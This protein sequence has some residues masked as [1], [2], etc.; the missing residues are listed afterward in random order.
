MTEL[1]T[2]ASSVGM[3]IWIALIIIGYCLV[4][5]EMFIPGFGVPGISGLCCLIVGIFFASGGSFQRGALLT[6][7]VAALC[8][9][10]LFISMRLAQGRLQKSR[11][12]LNE[13]SSSPTSLQTD[14]NRYV[15]K[16]GVAQTPLRPAGVAEIE[17][18]RVDVLTDGEFL[19][20]GRSVVVT[21]VEGNSVFVRQA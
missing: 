4:V 12:V 15:G 5:V 10:A 19:E 18:Q 17:G 11:L 9:L 20:S 8:G 13:T 2:W 16:S 6:L 7:I 21:R 3:A 14:L 1:L